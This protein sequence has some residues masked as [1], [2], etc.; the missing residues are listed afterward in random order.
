[1]SSSKHAA[2][3]PVPGTKAETLEL[4]LR[5]GFPVPPLLYFRKERWEAMPAAVLDE[6]TEHFPHTS[7]AVRSSA[8]NE[9]GCM[10]S[11]AG[12]FD[13]VLHVPSEDAA[14]LRAA[15]NKVALR[16]ETTVDFPQAPHLVL[17]T[18]ELS[19]EECMAEVMD[20][21]Q[22]GCSSL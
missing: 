20:T 2:Q 21:L 15:M 10:A 14:A 7:L 5:N 1:M 22:K 4:L 13:S 17:P 11:M 12:A 16:K 8:C 18:A 6:I 19:L 3:A 9:D